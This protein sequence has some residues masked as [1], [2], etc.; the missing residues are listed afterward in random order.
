M[1]MINLQ[2]MISLAIPFFSVC[3]IVAVVVSMRQ[4]VEL[5]AVKKELIEL[6]INVKESN[7]K[8]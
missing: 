1:I 8:H 5:R 4:T 3:F 2:M 7:G 6:N